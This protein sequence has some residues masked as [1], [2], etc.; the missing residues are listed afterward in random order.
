MAKHGKRVLEGRKAVDPDKLYGLGEAILSV[1]VVPVAL[2]EFPKHHLVRA[3]T[4]DETV[5]QCALSDV[6]LAN[7][8]HRRWGEQ[9]VE[10]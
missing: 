4:A 1:S 7:Q 10:V 9:L 6:G 5:E 8:D 3:P 2:T